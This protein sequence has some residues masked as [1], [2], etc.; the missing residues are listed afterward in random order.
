VELQ[1]TSRGSTE[2]VG[3]GGLGR[4]SQEKRV[5]RQGKK[6]KADYLTQHCSTKDYG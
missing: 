4:V 2:C 5:K 6:A 1:G 3:E